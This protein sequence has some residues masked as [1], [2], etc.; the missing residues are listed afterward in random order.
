M[1]YITRESIK[2]LVLVI[3]HKMCLNATLKHTNL[4]WLSQALGTFAN[5]SRRMHV[6]HTDTGWLCHLFG[7]AGKIH[8]WTGQSSFRA[9]Y[10]N[11][12]LHSGFLHWR[13]FFP[14]WL[15]GNTAAPHSLPCCV[16]IKMC[17]MLY[18][19]LLY[20]HTHTYTHVN[21]P[22]HPC[23]GMQCDGGWVWR[24]AQP[25]VELY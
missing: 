13:A 6:M 5:C 11:F 2:Y 15:A 1:C 18:G 20:T 12:D 8:A 16:A 25:C 4:R 17:L 14:S 10:V 7:L 3:L 23:E 21:T 22:P 9:K 24:K 19:R